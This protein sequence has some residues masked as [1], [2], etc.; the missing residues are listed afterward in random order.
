LFKEF[1]RL[2]NHMRSDVKQRGIT[3]TDLAVNLFVALSVATAV[4]SVITVDGAAFWAMV[5][6]LHI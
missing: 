4:V 1:E 6:R 3:V 5:A 2:V